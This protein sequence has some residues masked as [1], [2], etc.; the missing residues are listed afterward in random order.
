MPSLDDANAGGRAAAQ[1]AAG[2]AAR[3]AANFVPADQDKKL[4]LIQ[5]L[6]AQTLGPIA[7]ARARHAAAE[8]RRECRRAQRASPTAQ[9]AR[10]QWQ[11]AP[12]PTPPSG[13]PPTL[14]QAGAGRA[15]ASAAH[16]AGGLHRCR[17]KSTLADLRNYLQAEPVSV[18]NLPAD[19]KRQ[20][21]AADG[22]ARVEIAPKGNTNDNEVLRSFA[23]AVLAVVSE[24]RRRPDL[25]PGIRQ[26]RRAR[27]SS[28]PAPVRCCRSR[29]CCGSC[30]GA[31]ATCC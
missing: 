29:S 10:R 20:W 8:R 31:S 12:A 9:R 19:I 27:P 1:T 4:P 5:Q 2:R 18:D 11:T 26:H 7:A 14:T 22:R 3:D 15:G 16:G 25:D 30:C 24:R 13:S 17:C 28:R 21:L 23:R 6:A